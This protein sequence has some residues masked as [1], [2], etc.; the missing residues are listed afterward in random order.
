MTRKS[1]AGGRFTVMGAVPARAHSLRES[2]RAMARRCGQ[3]AELRYPVTPM[4]AHMLA[5]A[6]DVADFR[7]SRYGDGGCAGSRAQSA[8]VSRSDGGTAQALFVDCV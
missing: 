1:G 5:R 7:P 2:G 4:L 8:R 3:F 6:V